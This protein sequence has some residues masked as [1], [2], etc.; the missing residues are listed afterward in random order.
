MR[1][2]FCIFCIRIFPVSAG[3]KHGLAGLYTNDGHITLSDM[4]SKTPYTAWVLFAV[5]FIVG[6]EHHLVMTGALASP[7]RGRV[8][9]RSWRSLR[10]SPNVAALA[11]NVGEVS[12]GKSEAADA[13]G[14]KTRNPLFERIRLP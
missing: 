8:R 5:I 7:R 14:S 11:S 13:R 3:G 1:G 12:I 9:P 10:L 2:T 4:A 6:V